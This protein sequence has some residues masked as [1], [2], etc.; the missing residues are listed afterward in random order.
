MRRVADA[1]LAPIILALRRYFHPAQLLFITPPFGLIP[2][3][4]AQVCAASVVAFQ[5]MTRPS[6]TDRHL[7]IFCDTYRCM[8]VTV[9]IPDSLLHQAK[10]LA[11]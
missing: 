11:S 7:D 10:R 4:A 3:R 1:L 6:P 8:K 5:R 9:E 2:E